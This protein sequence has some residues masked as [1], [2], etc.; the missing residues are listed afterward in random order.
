MNSELNKHVYYIYI[1]ARLVEEARG[2]IAAFEPLLASGRQLRQD[3]AECTVVKEGKLVNYLNSIIYLWIYFFSYSIV[4][5]KKAVGST[6]TAATNAAQTTIEPSKAEKAVNDLKA[7]S[8]RL[9]FLLM[10]MC[11][12]FFFSVSWIWIRFMSCYFRIMIKLFKIL[13]IL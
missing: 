3:S 6:E 1:I 10:W 12:F 11:I 5:C 13:K 7:I 8:S 2:V 4:G 9:L